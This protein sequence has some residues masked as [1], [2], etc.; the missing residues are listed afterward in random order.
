MVV[1][2]FAYHLQNLELLNPSELETRYGYL[3]G[4][5]YGISRSD[6]A[7]IA[8]QFG[9]LKSTNVP[10]SKHRSRSRRT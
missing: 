8:D 6:E 10:S 9:S 1:L 5:T 7:V 2:G 4:T 3:Y